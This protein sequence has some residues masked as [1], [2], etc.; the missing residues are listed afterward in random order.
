MDRNFE[1]SMKLPVNYE[2]QHLGHRDDF[3]NGCERPQQRSLNLQSKKIIELPAIL[4]SSCVY[5]PE[6]NSSQMDMN[7]YED[8]CI[9]G[10]SDQNWRVVDIFPD[11]V[12]WLNWDSRNMPDNLNNRLRS[13][14]QDNLRIL[15]D[16]ERLLL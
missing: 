11:M 5:Q 12:D 1:F 7:N 3:G 8:G 4:T 13:N 2:R 14:H 16:Q 10:Y 6:P 15:V 9:F